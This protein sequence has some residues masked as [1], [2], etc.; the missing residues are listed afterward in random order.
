MTD[1]HDHGERRRALRR[2]DRQRH[3]G[4]A[5]RQLGGRRARRC[6]SCTRRPSPRWPPSCGSARS[7]SYEVL[8]AEVPDAE[9]AKRVE[10]AAFCW[11]IMG[12]GRLHPHRMP[13]SAS[14]GERSPTWPASSPPPGCAACAS[15]RCR[16]P[17]SA[18]ST[19]RSAARRRSTPPRA[20]TWSARSTRRRRWSATSTCS[21]RCRA[22]EILA[23]FG[24]VVKYGF[25]AEPEILD[26]IEAGRR[27]RHGP[28]QRR[29]P[30][31]GRAVGRH[32]GA[33]RRGGLHRS[34]AC[35]RSSTTATRSGTRSSTRSATSGATARRS[36]VGMM[37]AAELARLGGRLSDEVVDRHRSILTSLQLPMPIRS[38]AG[39]RCWRRCS[40]T[41]RRAAACCGSSCST[42]WPGRPC[43]PARTRACSS[44]RTRR[45]AS[46]AAACRR[47]GRASSP[48][49]RVPVKRRRGRESSGLAARRGGRYLLA[50]TTRFCSRTPEV[51][52]ILR[53][54]AFSLTG[55]V[56]LSTPLS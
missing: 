13:S 18:W 27:A 5:S 39:T 43:S 44:P 30:A 41:R 20:R 11:Q 1:D 53:G 56:T 17:C 54:V 8:L 31:P 51:I 33:R 48:V 26:I 46:S 14:A 3:P 49:A 36:R 35:G 6:S 9:P 25:I 22:D 40:A 42:T 52:S 15:S 4:P 32:Q 21:P 34:R 7:A 19:P 28:E 2:A 37:Y 23:G 16:P 55:M 29:V 47:P 38:A 45:S 10:V 24:E 12:T 50:P